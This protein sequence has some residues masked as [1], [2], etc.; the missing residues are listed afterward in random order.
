META[1]LDAAHINVTLIHKGFDEEGQCLAARPKR[2]IGTNMGPERL[3]Q[4]EAA[5]NVGDNL[6]QHGGATTSEHTQ[7]HIGSWPH[8]IHEVLQGEVGRDR[9]VA[10]LGVFE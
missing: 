7:G 9:L 4:L 10:V 6:W 8:H 3:H 2:R 5:P 1:S